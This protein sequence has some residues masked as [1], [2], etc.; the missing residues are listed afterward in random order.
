MKTKSRLLKTIVKKQL[1]KT[2]KL[3][4]KKKFQD[5]SSDDEKLDISYDDES[6]L[7]LNEEHIFVKLEIL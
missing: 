5:T 3:R 1:F 4:K 7:S 2:N 6:D